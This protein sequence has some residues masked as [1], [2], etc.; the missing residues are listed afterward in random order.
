MKKM[1]LVLIMLATMLGLAFASGHR[2]SEVADFIQKF[3]QAASEFSNGVNLFVKNPE[4]Q[5]A[6][7]KVNRA[8]AKMNELQATYVYYADEF[9]DSDINRLMRAS[10]KM[11]IALSKLQT[12]AQQSGY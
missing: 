5:Q 2:R 7:Q 10:E 8:Q 4:S 3:E 1:F 6:E 12:F 11:S 9:T